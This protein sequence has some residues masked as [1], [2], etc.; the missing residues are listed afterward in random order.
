MSDCNRNEDVWLVKVKDSPESTL[1]SEEEYAKAG[2]WLFDNRVVEKDLLGASTTI[3]Q[4][5]E[6]LMTN[7]REVELLGPGVGGSK[8][9]QVHHR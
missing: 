8:V 9:H 3:V 6:E 1:T 2:I 7:S 5:C 4:A